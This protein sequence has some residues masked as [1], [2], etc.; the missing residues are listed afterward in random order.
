MPSLIETTAL[1]ALG[2]VLAR[3]RLSILIYHRVL[4]ERD[5][6]LPEIHDAATFRDELTHVAERFNIL[7]LGEAIDR[8]RRDALPARAVCVTFDDGYADNCEVA[9]PVLTRLGV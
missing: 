6:L 3:R 9:L 8:L 4:R 7:P 1:R 2:S 5:P